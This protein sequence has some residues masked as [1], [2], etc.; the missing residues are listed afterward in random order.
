MFAPYFAWRWHHFGWPLPNT[1]YAKSELSVAVALRGARQL[2]CYATTHL[3]WLVPAALIVV[4][5]RRGATRGWRIAAALAG[6]SAANDV[7][8]GGD[9]FAFY[10]FLLPAIPA[11]AIALTGAA[12]ALGETRSAARRGAIGLGLAGLGALTFAA[13]LLPVTSFTTRRG[14][15]WRQYVDETAVVD[16]GY[17]LIGQGLQAMFPHGATLATNAAGIIPYVSG[18]R[19][20]DMLG[21]NDVHIAHAPVVALRSPGGRPRE[22]R[23]ALRPVAEAGRD[24]RGAPRAARPAARRSRRLRVRGRAVV[25]VL[26]GRR[27]ARE[28]ARL[29]RAV[30]ADRV[31][32]TYDQRWFFAFVPRASVGPA[33]P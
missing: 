23:R 22:A 28:R 24:P 5:R 2:E 1:Y 12:L 31:A 8:V 30:H 13:E 6:A 4:I 9:A 33:S 17:F 16:E 14:K 10:R 3:A 26:P 11:A 21:L 7:L 32:P 29:L 15:S 20:I 25:P 27:G 18:L 19:T